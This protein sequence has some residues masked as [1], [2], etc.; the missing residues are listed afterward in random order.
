[1]TEGCEKSTCLTLP[2]GRTLDLSRCRWDGPLDPDEFEFCKANG[3]PLAY[4]PV[5]FGWV[6]LVCSDTYAHDP[7][8]EFDRAG[9]QATQTGE[10]EEMNGKAADDI[11]SGPYRLRRW[12][13]D[14]LPDFMALL[15]NANV[16]TYLPESYPQPLTEDLA[17]D[18]IEVSNIGTHHDVRAIERDGVVVGQVRLQFDRDGQD[19]EI[20]YWIGEPHWGQGIGGDVVALFTAK[21]FERRPNLGSIIA[22]VHRENRASERLLTRA[23]FVRER[24]DLDNPEWMIQRVTREMVMGERPNADARYATSYRPRPRAHTPVPEQQPTQRRVSS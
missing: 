17:R 4:D 2:N 8:V 5:Q 1:M 16:W 15:G 7:H 19:T 21:S 10:P 18:L 6:P 13:L 20:S 11:S 14:D 23:G 3:I 12:T 24:F 22:R 9:P